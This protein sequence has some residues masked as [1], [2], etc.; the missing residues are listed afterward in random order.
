MP[1]SRVTSRGGVIPKG[2]C[3]G[4]PG[5]SELAV[6]ESPG[7]VVASGTVARSVDGGHARSIADPHRRRVARRRPV[8]RRGGVGDRGGGPARRRRRRVAEHLLG[9]VGQRRL[10]GKQRQH[11]LHVVAVGGGDQHRRPVDV[12]TGRLDLV[13]HDRVGIDV[14]HHAGEL[15]HLGG[16]EVAVGHHVLGG[17]ADQAAGDGGVERALVEDVPEHAA[18]EVLLGARSARGR[19]CRRGASRRS[20]AG[21]RT[22]STATARR[23][24]PPR[25]RRRSTRPGAR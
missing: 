8:A 24:A 11:G 15:H 12:P 17:G 20:P 1:V 18:Q 16:R 23:P 4:V 7:A 14:V 10:A 2:S 6:A 5:G 22:R 21:P 19:S 13:G 3:W 9:H 25:R